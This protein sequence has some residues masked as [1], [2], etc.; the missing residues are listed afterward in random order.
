M[1]QALSEFVENFLRL[2][3]KGDINGALELAEDI[4]AKIPDAEAQARVHHFVGTQMWS[5][6]RPDLS[7]KH[8]GIAAAL[9]ET[10]TDLALRFLVV[11]DYGLTLYD[12]GENALALEHYEIGRAI[13]PLTDPEATFNLQRR[14][15]ALYLDTAQYQAAEDALGPVP[16]DTAPQKMHLAWL[17]YRLLL[18]ERTGNIAEAQVRATAIRDIWDDHHSDPDIKMMGGAMISALRVDTMLRGEAFTKDAIRAL[19]QLDDSEQSLNLHARLELLRIEGMAANGAYKDALAKLDAAMDRFIQTHKHLAM[20]LLVTRKAVLELMG[21][22]ERFLSDLDTMSEGSLSAGTF[23]ITDIAIENS[24]LLIALLDN[25]GLDQLNPDLHQRCA[26]HLL[27]L[28]FQG[29][30]VETAW[31]ACAQLANTSTQPETRIFLAKC[32]CDFVLQTGASA[33]TFRAARRRY[34]AV[35]IAP[36]HTVVG[37]LY[38]Q[39]R[40]HEGRQ[41]A[42]LTQDVQRQMTF[43]QTVRTSPAQ[44][45]PFTAQETALRANLESHTDAAKVLSKV[46]W[47]KPRSQSPLPRTQGMGDVPVLRFVKTDD[48][49]LRDLTWGA[50]EQR[51]VITLN[52]HDLTQAIAALLTGCETGQDASAEIAILRHTLC[53]DIAQVPRV[54]IQAGGVLQAVPF[55]VLLE[56][57]VFYG[58]GPDAQSETRTNFRTATFLVGSD[59]L[60]GVQKEATALATI[61]PVAQ[62]AFDLETLRFA[63]TQGPDILH[64]SGHL[65]LSSDHLSGAAFVTGNTGRI[66]VQDVAAIINALQQETPRLVVLALCDSAVFD[67]AT[68]D[69]IDLPGL[70]LQAGSTAVIGASWKIAD[71]DAARFMQS[72]YPALRASQ[73]Q[74]QAFH[75]AEKETGFQGFKLFVRQGAPA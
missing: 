37:L 67:H 45:I 18:A 74:V 48:G 2:L 38:G 23:P 61:G 4:L 41:I 51:T 15:C 14:L 52:E 49:Y 69:S 47:T 70:F 35:R 20:D 28:T 68:G 73:N 63:C 55:G 5:R 32:A 10:S 42:A 39:G 59:E 25:A 6:Q 3:D 7:R 26:R 27:N 8:Y 19:G 22:S 34:M 17:N 50:H 40:L 31:Q 65:D 60:A 44:Q 64:I 11:C 53:A 12:Q 13:D 9:L 62:Y 16:A 66:N 72:F 30:P 75:E 33:L 24:A 43:A 36:F 71:D 1:Q 29:M 57:Q 58:S 56:G 21:Q 54:A 46:E